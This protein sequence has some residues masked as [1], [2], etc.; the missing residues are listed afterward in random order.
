MLSAGQITWQVHKHSWRGS[1]PRLLQL[2][3]VGVATLEPRTGRVTNKWSYDEIQQ[4]EHCPTAS[5]HGIAH[6]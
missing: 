1:Y 4:V 3:S 6:Q 2:G 5:M